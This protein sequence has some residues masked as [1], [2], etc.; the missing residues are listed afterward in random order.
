MQ[1]FSQF[2]IVFCNRD[3]L[4]FALKMTTEPT[5]AAPVE[6]TLEQW[7]AEVDEQS[8][9]MEVNKTQLWE[10][11]KEAQAK[12]DPEKKNPAVLWRLAKCTYK[13]ASDAEVAGDK[14]R[15]KELLLEALQWADSALALEPENGEAHAWAAYTCG[16]LSDHLGTKE[17]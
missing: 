6:Q 3:I 14:K 12:F 15:H 8:E 11:A 9:L 2:Q 10:K 16:K 1:Q 4:N 13:A 17:R 7:I 5:D